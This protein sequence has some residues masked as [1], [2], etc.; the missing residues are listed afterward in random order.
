MPKIPNF[1]Y[2]CPAASPPYGHPS[3]A[4]PLQGR[5]FTSYDKAFL[6]REKF[7]KPL[8][9]IFFCKF[10]SPNEISVTI[11]ILIRGAQEATLVSPSETPS[12]ANYTPL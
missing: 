7:K 2:D 3:A 6:N 12:L 8:W 5:I 4:T 1:H 11:V 10:R 9:N